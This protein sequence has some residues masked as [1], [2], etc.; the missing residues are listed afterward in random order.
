MTGSVPSGL[1]RPVWVLVLP[2]VHAL[3]FGGP[4][5]AIHEACGFGAPYELRFVGPEPQVRAAQGF[6]VADLNPLP[7]PT[8]REWILVP[9]TESSRLETLLVPEAWLRHARDCGAR[10]SSV[11]SGA[12]ALARAGLLEGRRCTTH[13]KLIEM[14]RSWCPTADVV[15]QCLYVRDGNVISSAGL[16]SGIDMTLSLIEEDGGPRIAGQVAREMVVYIRREGTSAQES[17][18]LQHRTH[19]HPGVHRVQDWIL[20]HPGKR[21]TLSELAGIAHCSPR[22]LTRVFRQATGTTPKTFSNKVKLEVTQNLLDS[23]LSIEEIAARCG[24]EDARQLRRLWR[25]HFGSSLHLARRRH[26]PT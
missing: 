5:Q 3:D 6:T 11:C 8:G 18:Y 14:L 17:V 26:Q 21:A 10:I 2:G 15:D 1:R 7:E 25:E 24:F 12:F 23:D 22:H 13:W 16:A 4:V 20:S 19:M 9:G